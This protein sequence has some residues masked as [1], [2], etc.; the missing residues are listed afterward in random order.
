MAVT[1][2]TILNAVAVCMDALL[3]LYAI[4]ITSVCIAAICITCQ[5][6]FIRSI[7]QAVILCRILLPYK[8]FYIPC[9]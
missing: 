3:F 8:S 1:V 7:V 2:R 9:S 6:A 5:A 4:C